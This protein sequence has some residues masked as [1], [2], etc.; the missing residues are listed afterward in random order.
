MQP[1]S[2]SFWV[3]PPAILLSCHHSAHWFE[4]GTHSS[5]LPLVNTSFQQL[6]L[7]CGSPDLAL[8][9]PLAPFDKSIMPQV[10]HSSV[11]AVSLALSVRISHIKQTDFDG[12][13]FVWLIVLRYPLMS[14]SMIIA[15][16]CM[17]SLLVYGLLAASAVDTCGLLSVFCACGKP[18]E[19]RGSR[20]H[21]DPLT[22]HEHTA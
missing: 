9:E 17:T 4:H 11:A 12:P 22:H 2:F 8:A 5:G 6:L 18:A 10:P 19:D 15:S 16:I 1:P 7:L 20:I 13:P 3:P 21:Q 14:P